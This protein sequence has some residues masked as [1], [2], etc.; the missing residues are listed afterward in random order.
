MAQEIVLISAYTPELTQIDRLRNLI[1]SLKELNYRICL[2]THSPTSQD[3]IDRCDYFIYDKE[4]PVLYDPEIKYWH[5]YEINNVRFSFKD[6]T[7]LSSH[8]LPVARMYLGALAYLKSLGEEIVHMCEHDTI[9]KNR[10]VWDNAFDKLANY[11]AVS[12]VFPRFLKPN[13]EINCTWTFQ[14]INVSK[15][16]YD[17]LNYKKEKLTQQY[18]NY[19][20]QGKLPVTECIFYDNIWKNLNCYIIPL[21]SEEELSNSFAINLDHSGQVEYSTV[22]FHNQEFKFFVWNNSKK[23]VHYDLIVDNNNFNI[24]VDSYGWNWVVLSDQEP[25]SIKI[26]KNNKLIK[27]LDMNNPLDKR[28]VYE[29]SNVTML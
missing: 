22:H 17:F 27:H 7:S 11:D 6:Y 1:N 16:S 8:I 18:Y 26:F 9:I 15:I 19:F 21:E 5:F 3:I 2:I 29:Y 14:S 12:Y 10:E 4:N 13:G 24:K 28:W 20:H 25:N 23:V